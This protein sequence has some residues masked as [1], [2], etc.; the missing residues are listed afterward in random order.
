VTPPPRGPLE[1]A[2]EILSA[3]EREQEYAELD[4]HVAA[5]AARRARRPWSTE[6]ERRVL[7]RELAARMGSWPDEADLA[8]ADLLPASPGD[9]CDEIVGA[10]D[11]AG[12]A[13]IVEAE[14]TPPDPWTSR[15]VTVSSDWITTAPAP[16][17][18]LMRDTRTGRGAIES[19]GVCILGAAGG[20][21]KSYT[22][23][24]AAVAVA[25]GTPWL[26]VLA[27]ERPG[28]ALIV[29]AEDPA[30]EMRRR[31][32]AHCR[33]LRIPSIP[34]GAIDIVD[35][36]DVH[37][38]L[39]DGTSTPTAYALALVE[40][41]RARGPYA[42]VVVDP[43]AR[44]SGASIDADNVAA[45][46]LVTVLESIATA[47]RGLVLAPHHTSQGARRGGITDATAL[48]GATALGDSA[49]MVLVL[50]V[51]ET[52]HD[53]IEVAARLGQL[54]TISLAKANHVRRW[55]P[56]R[57]RRDEH[58]VLLP[59]DAQD[60]AMLA[61]RRETQ[62]ETRTTSRATATASRHDDEDRALARI[63]AEQPGIPLRGLRAAMALALAGCSH[64]AV[65]LA[66]LRAG[67]RIRIESGARGARLHYLTGVS[68]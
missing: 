19:T 52:E 22:T 45:C 26:G 44:L 6:A 2:A 48:R 53:D 7:V 39:L 9:D 64:D 62:R 57:L 30:D 63:L 47:A 1:A 31:I 20:A 61:E 65:D 56:I 4:R 8:L 41:V 59:L 15:L 18:H 34:D 3:V 68:S 58:G 32:Y 36:H 35:V 14:A 17:E 21:G 16:R 37:L 10:D 13:A 40:M 29:T 33:A 28:H 38:P 54:V 50:S 55:D 24:G 43:L 12:P 27:P 11:G 5:E 42:L 66:I 23:I 60:V 49:R 51:A 25:T 67:P 46:A